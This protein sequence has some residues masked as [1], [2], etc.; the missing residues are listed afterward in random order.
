MK[1]PAKHF[2]MTTQNLVTQ[3]PWPPAYVHKKHSLLLSSI[4]ITGGNKDIKKKDRL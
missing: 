3:V 4:H 1:K 2:G